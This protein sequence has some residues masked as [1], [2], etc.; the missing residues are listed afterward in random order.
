MDGENILSNEILKYIISNDMITS[1][2]NISTLYKIS[3]T[4]PVNSATAE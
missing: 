2:T 1:Y 4:L 3:Y